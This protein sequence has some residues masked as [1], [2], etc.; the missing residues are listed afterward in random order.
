MFVVSLTAAADVGSNSHHTYGGPAYRLLDG[1][2]SK[3]DYHGQ[4]RL[5][6]TRTVLAPTSPR[7]QHPIN[8]PINWDDSWVHKSRQT[9]QTVTRTTGL[10]LGIETAHPR[11]EI[12]LLMV[13]MDNNCKK[14][15]LYIKCGYGSYCACNPNF[16]STKKSCRTLHY[17]KSKIFNY[18]NFRL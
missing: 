18:I 15:K 8:N 11:M 13:I 7:R 12:D 4:T 16:N 3:Y 14:F 5:A 6:P 10:W 1:G 17:S 2:Q 9:T